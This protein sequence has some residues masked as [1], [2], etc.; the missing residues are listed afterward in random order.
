MVNGLLK[1][2][3]AVVLALIALLIGWES[4]VRL[5]SPTAIE[6]HQAMIVAVIGLL[7]NLASAW[8]L[9]E[10]HGHHHH[11]H[12]HHHDGHHHHHDHA[13]AHHAHEREAAPASNG[14]APRQDG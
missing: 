1:S 11:G 3:S 4:V 14:K 6:F 2:N 12:H 10:D 8:L 13:S 9:R 5:Y 7:V